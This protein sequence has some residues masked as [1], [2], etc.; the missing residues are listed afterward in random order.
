MKR[1]DK[2][3]KSRFALFCDYALTSSDGKLSIIGEFDH[4]HSTS[5]KATLGKAFLIASFLGSANEKVDLQVRL[6]ND[7][8]DDELFKQTFNLTTSPEGKA[9]IIIEF[10]NLTFNKFGIYKAIVT[11]NGKKVSEVEL[12]VIKANSL[13]QARA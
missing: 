9:N 4:L 12:S 8:E 13:P 3:I 1:E 2:M 10:Q 7:K 5:D 6:V 11:E